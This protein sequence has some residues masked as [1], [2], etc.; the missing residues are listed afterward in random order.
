MV[1]RAS[2]SVKK[3]CHEVANNKWEATGGTSAATPIWA[4]GMALVEQALVTNTKQFVYG[5]DLYYI[6]ANNASK[7][8]PFFDVVSGNNLYYTATPYWDD[9]TGWGAPDMVNFYNA[10]VSLL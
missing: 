8:K 5:P 2:V 10:V 6:V 1:I 9:A 4:S 7:Y 3:N